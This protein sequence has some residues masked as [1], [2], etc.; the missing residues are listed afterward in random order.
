MNII[1]FLFFRYSFYCSVTT[2][3][4]KSSYYGLNNYF[5]FSILQGID[6]PAPDTLPYQSDNP[7]YDTEKRFYPAALFS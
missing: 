3:Y 5:L 2:Y 7:L 6:M 1:I 4:I